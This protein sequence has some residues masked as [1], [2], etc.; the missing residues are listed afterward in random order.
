MKNLADLIASLLLGAI[1]ASAVPTISSCVPAARH[2]LTEHP[3]QALSGVSPQQRVRLAPRFLP[4]QALR[5]QF[6]FRTRAE[7]RS[8]GLLEN[9]QAPSQIE[10]SALTVVRL[11]VLNVEP[12]RL[13]PGQ[14]QDYGGQARPGDPQQ[15]V[16]LRATYEKAVA[17]SRSDSYAPEAAAIEEQ[18]RKLQGHSIEFVVGPDGSL[19]EVEGLR[20]LL[21]DEKLGSASR[22]WLAQI[23]ITAGSP[24]EGIVVGQKWSSEHPLPS[25]PLAGMTWRTESTYL[26]DEPCWPGRP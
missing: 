23:A 21:P 17:T 11:E 26:R 3:G 22:D 18:Y 15:P 8:T 1:V 6:E 9:P 5:Y 12:A 4:G 16:R 20:E 7:G 19:S 25:A 14:N 2:S 10:L 13:P 24:P